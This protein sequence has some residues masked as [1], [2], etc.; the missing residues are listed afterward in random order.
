MPAAPDPGGDTVY[1]TGPAVSIPCALDAVKNSQKFTLGA[2]IGSA[3]AVMYLMLN[4]IPAGT[5]V[6]VNYLVVVQLEG[7]AAASYRVIYRIPRIKGSVSHF[8]LFLEKA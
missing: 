2:A 4:V 7:M 8:E 5:V 6:D 3:T 1:A